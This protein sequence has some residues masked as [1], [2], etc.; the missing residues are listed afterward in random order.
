M[1]D[2]EPDTFLI[3]NDPGKLLPYS[4]RILPEDPDA[5]ILGR[6]FMRNGVVIAAD[7]EV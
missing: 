3:D 6:R 1:S 5:E 7:I 4:R 2:D